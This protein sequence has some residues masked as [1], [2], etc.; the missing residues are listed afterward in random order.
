M[1]D[2]NLRYRRIRTMS[3][4]RE[5]GLCLA[6][7]GFLSCSRPVRDR[8]AHWSNAKKDRIKAGARQR[9]IIF[10]EHPSPG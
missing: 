7:A 2:P 3:L 8:Q 4:S 10:N 6:L 9:R 1:N 5:S